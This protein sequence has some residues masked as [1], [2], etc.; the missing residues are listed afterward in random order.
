MKPDVVALGEILIDFTPAGVSKTGMALYERNPGGAPANVAVAAARLGL[1]SAFIGKAGNDS[2][3]RFLKRVLET[4]GVDASGLRLDAACPTTLAFVDLKENGERDFAF[5]RKGCG[6]TRLE[7]GDIDTE[8]IRSARVLHV[9]TLSL[10]D[11]P[12]RGA[13]F[14][15]LG[16]AK[17]AG[18]AVSCD[19]NWRPALWESRESFV[20]AVEALLPYA[21]MLKA[22]EEEAELLTG[23]ADC[24]A[25]AEKLMKTFKLKAVTV[26]L[27]GSGA[28]LLT[29]EGGFYAPA[30]PAA[31]VD[32]TG[33]GD[34]FWGA[35][36][37][38]YLKNGKAVPEC[39]RLGCAAASIC[40][41]RRGAIPSLPTLAEVAERLELVK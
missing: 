9:G 7:A 23:S 21:E 34:C 41:E 32:T 39:A 4:E 28:Y 24:A 36:L 6:D 40:V 33:A 13:T 17:K 31:A 25:A 27:G 35:F 16:A 29:E 14:F 10:T 11:E 38:G 1:R 8:L 5:V 12:A 30:Y 26:T 22:S 37:Y 18:I 20:S 3:G 19:V 15:A 2:H